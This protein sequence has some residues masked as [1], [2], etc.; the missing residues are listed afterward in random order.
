MENRT[1]LNLI[2]QDQPGR[3]I[4]GTRVADLRP[5]HRIHVIYICLI[6]IIQPEKRTQNGQKMLNTYFLI[7]LYKKNRVW[8]HAT[9]HN[10]IAMGFHPNV[11]LGHT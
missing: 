5:F 9:L 1:V 2:Q 7:E 6:K 4:K 3:P 8:C 11:F 10:E